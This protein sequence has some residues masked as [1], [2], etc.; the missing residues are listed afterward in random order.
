MQNRILVVITIVLSL[1]LMVVSSKYN[2]TFFNSESNKKT[3]ENNQNILVK[4]TK[5]NQINNIDLEEYI[6]GVVAA[7]MPASFNSEAL[8]AQAIA[9]RTYAVYKMSTSTSDFDVVTD[10]SNQGYITISEMQEKWQQDFNTYYEKIKEAVMSTQGQILT[11]NDEIV[12]AYYFA[13]SNG[14]TEDVAL[15]FSEERDYLQSVASLSERNL[16]N[17]SVIKEFSR[18]EV[19]TKLAINCE[20]L[21]FTNIER[22][23]TNRVNTITVNGKEFKGT[24]FR[25]KLDLRSTDFDI[26][27]KD[28]KVI[29]TTRGYGHGVGMSQYGA[30]D[31]AKEGK[32][33]EEILKYYYKNVKISSI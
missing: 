17:F 5:N 31:L 26:E 22:S 15:V 2:T 33:Y 4:D 16:K 11:Y 13:M 28:N 18:E 10:V 7:E 3:T 29:I 32:N 27:I 23:N 30:N 25:Q 6:I 9:S 19:C 1:V 8:K 21:E 24:V 12:E 14:Y 20:N